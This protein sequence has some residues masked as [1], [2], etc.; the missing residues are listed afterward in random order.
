MNVVNTIQQFTGVSISMLK[1]K[2]RYL[3]NALWQYIKQPKDTMQMIEDKSEYMKTRVNSDQYELQKT[4]DE[5]LL[6]PDKYD[7]LKDF[8]AKHG[9]F[10]QRATQSVVDSITWAGAYNQ[11]VE[12]GMDEKAAVR[13]ADSAVRMTQGSFAPEDISR[14]E[15]GSAFMRAFTQFY[16]YFNM[17]ANLL[18]TEFLNTARNMGVKKG[19]GRL[20]YIYTFGYMA[21]AL[22]AELIVQ[23]A[24]GF[25]AGDDDD[26]ELWDALRLFVN[27]Q[28]RPAAAMVPGVGQL[29]TAAVNRFNNKY[30]D[31]RISTSPAISMLESS[32]SAPYSVYKAIADDGSWKRASKDVLNLLGAITQIPIGQLGKPV[33]YVMDVAQGKVEPEGGM[34]VA[35]GLISGKDVNRKQ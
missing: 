8:A 20:L 22:M 34:D 28:W 21:P 4:M 30:Y 3:R 1:V 16:S 29:V 7:K 25:D 14:I 18:G 31:D 15:T 32:I 11:A 17:Q 27:S 6:N 10:M 26:F 9:Y 23:A 13:E 2:P 12:Q 5:I 19:A 24:G 35:R 33:G